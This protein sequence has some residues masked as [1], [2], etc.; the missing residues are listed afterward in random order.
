LHAFWTALIYVFL[1]EVG[2]KTQ[3]MTVGFAVKYR[4]AIVLAAT[5]L[6]TGLL[7][8][9]SVGLGEAIGQFL[10]IFWINLLAGLAFIVFGI[11]ELQNEKDEEQE[12]SKKQHFGPFLTIT[13]SFL[14]AEIGD[15]TMLATFAIATREKEFFQVW[16]GSTLGLFSCNAL[17]IVAGHFLKNY[18]SSKKLKYCIAAVYI[19]SGLAAIKKAFFP[20]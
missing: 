8:L 15:K 13:L 5:L 11:L 7:N 2:D 10:S 16:A 17:A 19:L 3:L 6:A 12:Q 1:A 4:P 14:M 9:L 18:L 20:I